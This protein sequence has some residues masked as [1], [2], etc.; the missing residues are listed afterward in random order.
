MKILGNEIKIHSYGAL[1]IL[2]QDDHFGGMISMKTNFKG[3]VKYGKF[4][5]SSI[6]E[7]QSLRIKNVHQGIKLL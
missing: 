1:C 2:L 4:Y 5:L 3:E 7:N 6:F